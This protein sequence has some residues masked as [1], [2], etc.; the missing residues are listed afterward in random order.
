MNNTHPSRDTKWRTNAPDAP[1]NSLESA[2][3]VAPPVMF[4]WRILDAFATLTKVGRVV[5]AAK[6]ATA[7]EGKNVSSSWTTWKVRP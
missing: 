1:R 7:C 2:R 4:P 3:I 6:Q 5:C